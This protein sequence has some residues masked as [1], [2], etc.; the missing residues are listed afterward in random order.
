MTRRTYHHTGI[1]AQRAERVFRYLV[2]GRGLRMT[3]AAITV[4]T[5]SPRRLSDLCHG[6]DTMTE[7]A[8]PA[9]LA[10]RSLEDKR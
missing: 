10:P 1:A 2:K 6:L 5:F 4:Q 8:G 9:P 7:W 3:E